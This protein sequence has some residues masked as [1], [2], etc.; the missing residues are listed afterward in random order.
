MSLDVLF[1]ELRSLLDA[2][3]LPVD[4]Y[5]EY[6]QISDSWPRRMFALLQ[7]AHASA[8]AEYR[9]AW[10]PYLSQSPDRWLEPLTHVHSLKEF[11]EFVDFLA[12]VSSAF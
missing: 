12:A 6:V 1:G 4:I 10:I 9:E 5:S 3:N 8:P 11:E 2:P 7:R